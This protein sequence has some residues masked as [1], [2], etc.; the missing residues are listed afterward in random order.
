MHFPIIV[1]VGFVCSVEFRI[2]TWRWLFMPNENR[3][4]EVVS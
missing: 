3:L 2:V 4:V 1:I